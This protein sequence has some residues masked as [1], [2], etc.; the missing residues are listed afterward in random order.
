MGVWH[1]HS[2]VLSLELW[3]FDIQGLCSNLPEIFCGVSY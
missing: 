3:R 1:G 2:K